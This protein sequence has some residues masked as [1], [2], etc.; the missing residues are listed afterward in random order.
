MSRAPHGLNL[1]RHQ[2]QFPEE[3]TLKW[4]LPMM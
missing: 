3:E 2:I 4:H 1:T